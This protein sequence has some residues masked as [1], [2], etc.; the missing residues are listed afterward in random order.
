MIKN[1][2]KLQLKEIEFYNLPIPAGLHK[3]RPSYFKT[4]NF[5]FFLFLWVILA[6][7]DPLT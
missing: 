6:L 4:W 7:L 2:K 1:L 5:Y 3:R